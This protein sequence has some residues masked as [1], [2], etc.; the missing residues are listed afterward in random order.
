MRKYFN[1]LLA[2]SFIALGFVAC[3]DPNE[4][5]KSGSADITFRVRSGTSTSFASVD[6]TKNVIFDTNGKDTL[7]TLVTNLDSL[8][9]LT[10][11]DSLIPIISGNK[12][13]SIR[14]ETKDTI[15][16]KYDE[17]KPDTLN[18]RDTVTIITVAENG[19]AKRTFKV[20]VNIHQHDPDLYTWTPQNNQI[21][22]ENAIAEK[23]VFFDSLLY[24]YVKTAADVKLFIS[25]EGEKWERKILTNFPNSFD[26]KYIVRNKNHLYIA[27]NQDVYFSSDGIS[28]TKKV[29][30]SSIH[31][32]AF[33]LN[34]E[35]FGFSGEPE[36]LQILDTASMLWNRTISLPS[37][38]PVESA[39]ICVSNSMAG[40]E[41]V[42]LVGGKDADGNLLSTV[43][44]SENGVTWRNLASINPF[45]GR[46]DVAAMQ[47]DNVLMVFGG[48]DNGGVLGLDEYF[49]I[50]PDFGISWRNSYENMKMPIDLMP[51]FNCQVVIN[52]DK[53]KIYFVGGQN[54]SGFIKDA[55]VVVKNSVLWDSME[56]D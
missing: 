29:A 39:S 10:K 30:S 13:S 42:F 48:R 22:T 7:Y 49:K 15:I 43:W 9:Y 20:V 40:N 34:G 44:S 45:S 12:L 17:K 16:E 53:T 36:M 52:D 51:R 33:A 23:L 26:I 2:I 37:G 14:I 41:R 55:W 11:P 50:S 54:D 6:F 56:D 24:L 35:V 28:W 3:I 5:E 31:H 4:P 46:R 27:E 25:E 1:Y 18:F 47:Y 32:L 21:Y 8:P 38:F 19:I